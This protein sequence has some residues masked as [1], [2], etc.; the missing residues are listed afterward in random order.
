MERRRPITVLPF[1]INLRD[2]YFYPTRE[3]KLLDWLREQK[4][5]WDAEDDLRRRRRAKQIAAEIETEREKQARED[6]LNRDR[7]YWLR[8]READ[9]PVMAKLT[10]RYQEIVDLSP[11]RQRLLKVVAKLEKEIRRDA[12]KAEREVLAARGL[13]R[14][15][16]KV[17]LSVL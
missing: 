11:F 8:Q 16:R 3:E 14:G 12:A 7:D 17:F 9:R 6:R 2:Y 13:I 10:E 15:R 1:G 5:I 4:R